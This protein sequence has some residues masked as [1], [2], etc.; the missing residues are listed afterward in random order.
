MHQTPLFLAA[1]TNNNLDIV[2]YLLEQGADKDIWSVNVVTPIMIAATE[3][4]VDVV[5]LLMENGASLNI[6]D[7][8]D[9]SILFLAAEENQVHI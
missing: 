1:E 7:K 3:G 2:E 6:C 5:K 9:K 8:D 4:H